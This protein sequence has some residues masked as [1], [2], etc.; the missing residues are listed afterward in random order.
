MTYVR[1]KHVQAVS[2]GVQVFTRLC[3]AV[4][5]RAMCTGRRRHGAPQSALST[6]VY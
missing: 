3:T 1:V 2:A 5:C 4:S 6:E